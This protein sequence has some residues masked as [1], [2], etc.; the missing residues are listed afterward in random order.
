MFLFTAPTGQVT[1]YKTNP[2][3]QYTDDDAL[4][5]DEELLMGL[6]PTKT[7]TEPGKTF[8]QIAP[9]G[10]DALPDEGYG[11]FLYAEAGHITQ[12]LGRYGKGI[13][14]EGNGTEGCD[15]TDRCDDN[16][17]IGRAHV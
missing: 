10:S 13:R 14:R 17:K 16:S 8:R 9:P 2:T 4:S 15:K 1:K 6:D 7:M 12:R 11:R 3:T 5:D